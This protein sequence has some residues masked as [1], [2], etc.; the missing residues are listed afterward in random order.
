MPEYEASADELI[1]AGYAD[2][3]R[4]DIP[5]D[6]RTHRPS[7]RSNQYHSRDLVCECGCCETC[8]AREKYRVRARAWKAKRLEAE[9]ARKTLRP[10]PKK[11]KGEVCQQS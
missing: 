11:I 8:K 4:E 10:R 5:K 6:W 7:A 1:E 2:W 3:S 9:P